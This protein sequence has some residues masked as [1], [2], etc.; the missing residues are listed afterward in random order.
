MT[1]L[2][3]KY[4]SDVAPALMKTLGLTNA[5]SVPK[6]LKV[7]INMGFNSTVDK[8]AVK[9]IGDDLGRITGQ[10]AVITKAR[11]SISNFKLREGMPVG[12]KV[13]L[14]GP[15]MFEFLERLI[16][17]ALPRIRDFRGLS[18]K[19]FD[20][21]G[22]Y[23]FGLQE[24]TIFPEIDP[25]SVKKVQGMNVT[26]VTSADTDDKARELLTMIG[27]PFAKPQK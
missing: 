27:I 25:D 15:R 26:I 10:R 4:K 20:G 24:Q 7:T 14:R 19:G 18:P 1:G 16:H 22:S 9:A 8:D 11:K 23:T 3:A 21:R 13:T 2:K 12:A 6:L 5:M 17:A